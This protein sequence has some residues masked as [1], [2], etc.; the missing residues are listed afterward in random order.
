MNSDEA[1]SYIRKGHS[2]NP[3]FQDNINKFGERVVEY[4]SEAIEYY[5]NRHK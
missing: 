4:I 2:A 5:V 3:E 1:F